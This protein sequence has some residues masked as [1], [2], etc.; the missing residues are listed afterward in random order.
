MHYTE[1]HEW[2]HLEG[3]VATVGITRHAQ[4]ELGDI[5]FVELPKVGSLIKAGDEVAVLES[6]K[7]AADIYTPISGKV[8]HVNEALKK[9]PTLLNKDPEKA[10][11]IFQV[12]PSSLEEF[13]SLLTKENYLKNCS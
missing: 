4:Q 7:A 6:T 2:V 8:I 11:W 10:G 12:E 1:S 13:T 9:D 5:V 3:N